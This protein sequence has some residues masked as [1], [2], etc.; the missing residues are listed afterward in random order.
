MFPQ[1]PR[2]VANSR[3]APP[4]MRIR[5]EDWKPCREQRGHLTQKPSR[6]RG[7][8]ARVQ[9][10]KAAF[11]LLGAGSASATPTDGGV[12]CE[13]EF[14]LL[15][16]PR[17]GGGGSRRPCQLLITQSWG[18]WGRQASVY[19]H[20]SGQRAVCSFRHQGTRLREL[21]Q[22]PCWRKGFRGWGLSDSTF[23]IFL[24]KCQCV[25]NG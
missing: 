15:Y 3:A 21:S 8:E 4:S 13:L 20:I 22:L 5:S 6:P 11:R 16:R 9:E 2:D 12:P 19:P 1:Q 7:R 24:K 10:G 25:F 17:A 23:V 14:D 18:V